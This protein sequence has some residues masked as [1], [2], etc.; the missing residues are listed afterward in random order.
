MYKDVSESELEIYFEDWED[1]HP[2]TRVDWFNQVLW[3]LGIDVTEPTEIEIQHIQHR[4]RYNQIVNCR[5]WV[6]LERTDPEWLMSD[7]CSI[8]ALVASSDRETRKDMSRMMQ[9]FTTRQPF[10]RQ[11]LE[12]VID[13]LLPIEE[14]KKETYE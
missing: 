5:R 14:F 11:H 12:C 9:T 2:T 8:E 10:R 7:R 4:N 13:E 1:T 3:V 6:G